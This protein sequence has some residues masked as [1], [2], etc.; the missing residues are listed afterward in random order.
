MEE[1]KVWVSAKKAGECGQD[2]GGI[3]ATDFEYHIMSM[4]V[5]HCLCKSKKWLIIELVHNHQNGSSV[6]VAL[7]LI[8]HCLN[9]KVDIGAPGSAMDVTDTARQ[10]SKGKRA[11]PH[12]QRLQSAAII[13][14][15]KTMD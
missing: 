1:V 8:T 14:L 2:Q 4:S 11:R 5:T 13:K 7:S 15:E 10:V 3:A 9:L 12:R 6:S